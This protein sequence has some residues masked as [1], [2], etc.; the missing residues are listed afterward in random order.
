MRSGSSGAQRASSPRSFSSWARR[1]LLLSLFS[2]V[3]LSSLSSS[4]R[5]TAETSA[6]LVPASDTG[7]IQWTIGT[8]AT[9]GTNQWACVND[10]PTN[11]GDTSYLT[12]NPA[13]P[14]TL[15]STFDL[16]DLS[17]AGDIVTVDSVTVS[18]W[19]KLEGLGS[20]GF[21]IGMAIGTYCTWPNTP[22]PGLSTTYLNNTAATVSLDC[23]GTPAPFTLAEVQQL[24]LSVV[25]TDDGIPPAEQNC[26]ATA[27]GAL[28]AYT[29]LV[30]SVFND[31][32]WLIIILLSLFALFLILGLRYESGLLIFISGG[33]ATFL[34]FAAFAITASEMILAGLAVLGPGLLIMGAVIMLRGRS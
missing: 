12:A 4:V 29:Y 26:R 14:G 16:T 6:Y 30:K 20:S 7:V 3:L 23:A 11:D 31:N 32:E 25:C 2:L 15:I 1:C 10:L 5:A 21:Y 18:S 33:F 34:A 24:R 8:P 17:P 28:I 19:A 9:C 13:T 22:F 27:A